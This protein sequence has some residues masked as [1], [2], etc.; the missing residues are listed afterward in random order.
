MP[1]SAGV[2]IENNFKGGLITE[3]TG[4]N[5]PENACTDTFDCEFNLDG[6]VNRRLGFDYENNF[7]LKNIDRSNNVVNTYLWRNV[8]GDGNVTVF[9]VQIGS[10]LYFYRT[11]ANSVSLGAVTAT[12]T[13]TPVSGAPATS[14]IEAQFSDGNGYL[15][16][17]HPYC[18][19]IRVAYNTSNDNVTPTNLILQIRDFEGDTTDALAVDARPAVSMGT[20]TGAHFYNLQNQGWTVTNLNA[21]DAAQA[22]MP[23]NADV[24]WYF[25]NS[26]ADFDFGNA[27]IARQTI[28]NTAAPK[29]H[30]ISTLSNF[31][32]GAV[33]GT[34][35]T[36]TST[37]FQRPSTSAFFAGRVFYAGIN[38]PKFNSNIYFTQILE[39]DDQYANCYQ[40][41]DPTSEN[42]FDLLPSDGGVIRIPEAGTIFKLFAVPGGLAVFAANGVWFITGSSGIGFAANDYTSQKITKIATISASSFVD[43]Q[44]YPCWWNSEGIYIMAVDGSTTIPTVTPLTYTTIKRYYDAIPLASKLTAKGFYN[45]IDGT[46]QWLFRSTSTSQTTK[47]YEYDSIL[48]FNVYIK[49]FYP[50]TITSNSNVTVNALFVIDA[51]TGATTL[52]TVID[53]SGNNVVDGSGNQLVLFTQTGSLTESLQT[54]YMVSYPNAG[55]YSITFA[56]NNNPNYLDWFSFDLVGVNYSSTFTTGFKLRGEG[57]R[58]WEATWIDLYS[59]LDSPVSYTFQGLWDYALNT[60]TARWTI[61]QSVTHTDLNYGTAKRRLKLRGHGVA[62]QFKITSVSGQPFDIIGWSTLDTVNALP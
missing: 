51:I 4:L 39:H 24:Q 47:V 50:W 44:G 9:V 43:V 26:T 42:L 3:A 23:S 34:S 37:G 40:T 28:G 60:S 8:S 12:V 62:A 57:I 36:V 55:T 31:D 32:R 13:L 25:K 58:K 52:D 59:R 41:N 33:G 17:T 1:R 15:I 20:I 56:E 61:P 18:E 35:S 53:G 6:S 54:K 45:Y 5:F 38:T 27:S 2:A 11:G 16:V 49:A 21:W 10:T 22:N 48:N 19:P 29:G 46:I 30:F 14:T 7:T